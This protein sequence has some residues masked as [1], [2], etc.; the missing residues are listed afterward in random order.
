[1]TP[2]EQAKAAKSFAETWKDKTSEIQHAQSFWTALLRNVFGIEDVENFIE[3][4]SPVVI[5][6]TGHIDGYIP[7]TKVLIEHKGADVDLLKEARQ[8]DGAML[9][10]FQQA[11]R[12]ADEMSN[13]R[14]PDIIVVCNFHEFHIYDLNKEG[15]DRY[16][17]DVVLL[18]DLE[19]EYYRLSFLVDETNV[20]LNKEQELTFKSG[21]LVG[22]LYD[23]LKVQ[24]GDESD[25][26]LKNL[27]KLCV[28]LVFCLYAEDAGIFG[29]KSMFGDYLKRFNADSL[30]DALLNLF[31]ILDQKEN[32]RSKYE[33]PELLEFPYVNGGLFSG[34]T[35][36]EIPQLTE[37]IK[38]LLV[39]KASDDF[40]WSQISP[41]IFGSLFESTLNLETRRSGGMHYTSIE[42]IHKVIDPLFMNQLN[43]EFAT[44]KAINTNKKAKVKEK[45][46][47]LKGL[48]DKIS[49]L[50]F[51]DPACGSGNFLTETYLSLRRL[52]N[53]I[54]KELSGGTGYLDLGDVIKVK[55]NQFYGIEIN[56]FA[57]AVA[58][59]ALWIAESQMLAETEGIVNQN[60][61]FLPLKSNA[62]I[63]EGNALRM[64]WNDLCPANELSYIIGNP[65]FV[66]SARLSDE[67]K[68]DR[69]LLF[70]E[71][72]GELDYV[73]CWYKK[74]ADYV[75]DNLICSAFVST[76]SICQGQQVFPLWNDLINQG[77]KI[78]FAYRTFRWDNGAK[79]EAHV[80]CVIIGFSRT[81]RYPIKLIF[82][83]DNQT[84]VAKNIN[85]YLC[86]APDIL[87]Q[88]RNEP[89]PNVPVVIKGYQP[90]DGGFLILDDSQKKA[91]INKEPEAANWIKPLI[92]AKE[93]IAGKKRWCLWLVDISPKQ[94][95]SIDGIKKR[96]AACKEWR[97]NQTKTGDAYKLKDIPYLMRPCK[98]YKG[99]SFIVLP[100]HTT[101]NR[102][103]IPMGF[104]EEGSIPGNSVSIVPNATLYDFGILTSIVHMAWMRVVCGRIKSDYRYSVEV[105]YNNFP[106]PKLNDKQR[107][108]IE[109]TAQLIL[110][111]RNK[112]PD[113]SLADFYDNTSMP[114]ELLKAHEANDK[115]VMEAYGFKP[116][117]SETDI[118]TELFKMYEKLTANQPETKTKGRKK[119]K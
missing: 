85:G 93:Y 77:F 73:A 89:L 91:L 39:T 52:E 68:Q 34:A 75:G 15:K 43:E 76:N 92:T 83:S 48:Q 47:A 105:V 108:K 20:H 37:E 11:K 51:L 86:D 16:K 5:K 116:T 71:K 29:K 7:A 42:N 8:S 13:T 56:D 24:Y 17:P 96:V 35:L 40:D 55:I 109:Q 107:E 53:K 44:A 1:M 59:T 33:K 106:W 54:L 21:E 81:K 66:G 65:P 46:D 70:G 90:T 100:L 101:E 50:Q 25:E 30:R 118:V 78:D 41:T 99:G 74:A 18:K 95:N 23:K 4:Q 88:K 36:D 63:V 115:A 22:L 12:Y 9:T 45:Q 97:T 113:S 58:K 60:F 82:T 119:A 79:G 110:D 10:P 31:R 38:T 87:I 117:M 72:G 3:F 19:K 98:K 114:V 6:N 84:I 27:N 94:L 49:K 112:Y 80:H 57:V 103:Y 69:A 67:Q 32:E 104:V 2:K 61:D 64:D 14:R 28:R 102:K 26:N 62:N 111:V